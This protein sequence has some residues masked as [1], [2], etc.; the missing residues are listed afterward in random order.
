MTVNRKLKGLSLKVGPLGESDRLITILSDE[1]GI[2]RLA[3]PGARRP[4]SNFAGAIPLTLLELQVSGS[5]GL[6][7]VKQLQVVHSF[8]RVGQKLETLAASQAIAQLCLLLV[9]TNNPQVGLLNTVLMHLERIESISIS[10]KID[11]CFLLASLVQ[12]YVHL[13]ALGGYALPLQ[14]CCRTGELLN[15]PIGKWEWRCSLIENEGFVIGA[16]KNAAM[17][18]N[19]SELALLQ[20]LVRSELPIGKNG[21]LLGPKHVWLRLLGVV[22]C[23]VR[24]HLSDNIHCLSM[25]REV[26]IT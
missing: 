4:K 26:L 17:Q 6:S 9:T 7:R 2:T 16:F 13:L 1:E 3:V 15:P 18:L 14:R 24:A 12:A 21:Q 20:R 22:E 23:W 19:P 11:P 8:N 10:E 5:K 25:L